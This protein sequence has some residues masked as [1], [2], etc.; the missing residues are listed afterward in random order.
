METIQ[1]LKLKRLELLN[2]AFQMMPNS[3]KQLKLRKEIFDLEEK[4]KKAKNK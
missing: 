3:P 1:D 2:K 4:I